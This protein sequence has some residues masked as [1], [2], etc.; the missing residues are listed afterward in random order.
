REVRLLSGFDVAGDGRFPTI[1]LI[2]PPE[3]KSAKQ[4]LVGRN[5]DEVPS[6]ASP[7]PFTERY[8]FL[9]AAGSTQFV[10]FVVRV[11]LPIVGP[12]VSQARTT[13]LSQTYFFPLISCE[14]PFSVDSH[15]SSARAV[16]MPQRLREKSTSKIFM[17][18]AS[19]M[20]G[21]LPDRHGTLKGPSAFRATGRGR[22][23]SPLI[24][25][26]RAVSELT[27]IFQAD[28]SRR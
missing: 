2:G 4:S 12:L 19:S 1:Q 27:M 16:T 23:I 24:E 5:S 9:S 26:F 28:G 14:T 20:L 13:H 25:P 8:F 18:P 6:G 21:S 7:A 11:H 10:H 17:D 22:N 15:L 3:L